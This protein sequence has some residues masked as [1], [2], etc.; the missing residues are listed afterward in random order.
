VHGLF[1]HGTS[2]IGTAVLLFLV[3]TRLGKCLKPQFTLL[4]GLFLHG[5][6]LIGILLDVDVVAGIDVDVDVD[7]DGATDVV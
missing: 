3:A 4:Q 5:V 6:S 2:F 1:L 7:V